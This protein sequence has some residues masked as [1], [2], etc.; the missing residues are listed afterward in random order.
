LH[1]SVSAAIDARMGEGAAKDL[2]AWYDS[3]P[4]ADV[5][6][7]L[8]GEVEREMMMRMVRKAAGVAGRT[9]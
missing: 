9:A 4:R 2:L 7:V 3:T 5:Q 6:D 8:Q 1:R